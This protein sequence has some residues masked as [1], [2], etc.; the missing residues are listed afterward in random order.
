MAQLNVRLD[1]EQRRR[2]EELAAAKAKS[3]SE[4]VRGLIDD[5]YEDIRRERRRQAVERLI[6]LEVEDPPDAATLS[7][8]LEAADP[9]GL[10]LTTSAKP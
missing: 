5:A 7:R 8:E 9:I 10:E 4:I 3:I 1:A 6:R 2:L